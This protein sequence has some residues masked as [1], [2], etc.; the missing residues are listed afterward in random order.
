MVCRT[1][2]SYDS[3]WSTCFYDFKSVIIFKQSILPLHLFYI[4]YC[5]IYDVWTYCKGIFSCNFLPKI[6]IIII[7]VSIISSIK[8]KMPLVRGRDWLLMRCIYM[9]L[10][11][12]YKLPEN[13]S[14]PENFFIAINIKK[15][16]LV[17]FLKNGS[18]L[19]ENAF[20]QRTRLATNEMHLIVSRIQL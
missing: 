2:G 20:S 12:N 10:V 19:I 7:S 18:K 8:S 11:Y 17:N 15:N 14:W 16:T 9:Y 3:L 13:W 1:M 5:R 4:D 6:I